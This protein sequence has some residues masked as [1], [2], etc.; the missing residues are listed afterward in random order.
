M[1]FLHFRMCGFPLYTR[2]KAALAAAESPPWA[3][4]GLDWSAQ[5]P[6]RLQAPPRVLPAAQSALP[7]VA[8]RADSRLT[9]CDGEVVDA[10]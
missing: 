4:A 2:L 5:V 6:A 7:Q 9:M 8:E 1:K 3:R 10:G